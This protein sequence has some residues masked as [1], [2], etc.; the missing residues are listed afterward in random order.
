[1]K[2]IITTIAT[3]LLATIVRATAGLDSGAA[4]PVAPALLS[5]TGLYAGEGTTRIDPLNRPFSPQYPLWTDGAAKKRW[6]R[7]P[8]SAAIDGSNLSRWEFPVG[9]KFWKEFS[10]DGRKVETRL[11]WR[12]SAER[13]VFASYVWN[14]AQTDAALA[15]EAGIPGIAEVAPGKRHSIPSIADCRACHDSARTEILGFDA[16]NLSDDRDPNAPHAEPLTPEMLTLKAL[17]NES[18]LYPKRPALVETPPR[19]AASSPEA[20]AALGYLSTNCGNCH[21]RESSIASLGLLLKHTVTESRDQGTGECSAA[22]AT[23]VGKRGHWVVPEAQEASR[24]I[25]PGHP[26]SSAVVRRVKSRR[27]S[28]QMPPLGSVVVDKRAVDLLTAWVEGMKSAECR[29][30]S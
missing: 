17:M 25:N 1:M 2:T 27:P 11:L 12:V 20:R 15:P 14:D 3:L 4:A 6:I 26:E 16:L 22:L 13:W 19:I 5:Q 28:S 21:N 8:Q 9:T 30:Q 23:T 10:F 7:L 18:L 24:L 29:V